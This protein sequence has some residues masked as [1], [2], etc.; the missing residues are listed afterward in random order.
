M[1]ALLTE[2]AHF[3]VIEGNGA[4]VDLFLIQTFQLSYINHVIL[5]LTC[6]IRQYP[7][8]KTLFFKM[9]PRAQRFFWKWVLFAWEWKVIFIS[10]AEHLASFWYRG[11]GELGNGLFPLEKKRG[12]YQTMSTSA[13]HSL[14]RGQGYWTHDCKIAYCYRG[15]CACACIRLLVER[16]DN[17]FIS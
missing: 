5:M 17:L 4:G 16:I 13:S 3:A 9:R 7:V 14:Q 12:L 11:P 15:P 2:T 1:F 6:V 8:R 10:K